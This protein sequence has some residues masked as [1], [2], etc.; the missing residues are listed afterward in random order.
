MLDNKSH[1]KP[2]WVS[3]A[4]LRACLKIA[5]KEKAENDVVALLFL[6]RVATQSGEAQYSDILSVCQ[7]VHVSICRHTAWNVSKFL[8]KRVLQ[9]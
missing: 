8:E 9:P 6:P 2:T 1:T 3:K 7:S 4:K 5:H